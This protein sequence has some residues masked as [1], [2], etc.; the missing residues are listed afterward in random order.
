MATLDYSKCFKIQYDSS[1]IG[2]AA[3]LTQSD[4]DE[5][6]LVAFDGRKF[7]G[8]KMNYDTT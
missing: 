3:V 6:R 2:T 5:E 8:D 1:N 4:D 7:R